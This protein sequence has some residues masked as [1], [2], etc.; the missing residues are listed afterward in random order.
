MPGVLDL[1]ESCSVAFILVNCFRKGFSW[2]QKFAE[3]GA[4]R[5]IDYEDIR[6]SLPAKTH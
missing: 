4:I 5:A 2:P 1:V 6:T 3:K